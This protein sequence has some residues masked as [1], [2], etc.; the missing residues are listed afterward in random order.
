MEHT[1]TTSRPGENST[2]R[3]AEE[4][5]KEQSE[6]K[7][8]AEDEEKGVKR[9]IDEWDASARKLKTKAETRAEESKNTGERVDIDQ[10]DVAREIGAASMGESD[11]NFDAAVSKFINST[12]RESMKRSFTTMLCQEKL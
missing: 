7:S 5:N 12:W 10:F 1:T 2:K 3:K 11:V 8:K 6:K 4:E 9:S